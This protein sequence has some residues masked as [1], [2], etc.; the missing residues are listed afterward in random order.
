[1]KAGRCP[2]KAGDLRR[3]DNPHIPE[4]LIRRKSLFGRAAELCPK[5]CAPFGGTLDP[6]RRRTPMLVE[7]FT[8]AVRRGSLKYG[9]VRRRPRADLPLLHSLGYISAC[10]ADPRLA[11]VGFD[12]LSISA[13]CA[14]GFRGGRNA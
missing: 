6:E 8:A 9:A 1:M 3:S 13:L 5:S 10:G 4:N 11:D 7:Q 2:G 14:E 12:N